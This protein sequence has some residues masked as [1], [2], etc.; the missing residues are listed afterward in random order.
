MD[1]TEGVPQ[2]SVLGGARSH[3]SACRVC[4]SYQYFSADISASSPPLRVCFE[5]PAPR[6]HSPPSAMNGFPTL[7]VPHPP[8]YWQAV[9][10][11]SQANRPGEQLC[12]AL[13]K[14]EERAEYVF[15]LWGQKPQYYVK[16]DRFLEGLRTALPEAC[17]QPGS[18]IGIRLLVPHPE[19][20]SEDHCVRED[21]LH[22]WLHRHP[23]LAVDRVRLEV[24][25]EL[26]KSEEATGLRSRK[27]ASNFSFLSI[28]RFHEALDAD[29]VFARDA[30]N[31]PDLE[32]ELT[33]T[34]EAVEAG[35]AAFGMRNLG[36][37]LGANWVT[38]RPSRQPFL[39]TAMA[40]F[41]RE[42]QDCQYLLDEVYLAER[43]PGSPD[44]VTFPGSSRITPCVS[45]FHDPQQPLKIMR[46]M[47]ALE[48][49]ALAVG[50]QSVPERLR[51][52]T[53]ST[54]SPPPSEMQMEVE[55]TV[56]T[57]SEPPPQ[58]FSFGMPHLSPSSAVT[59]CAQ[60]HS[61][62]LPPLTGRSR[63][64]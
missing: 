59:V 64:V 57:P 23:N 14:R 48:E 56:R 54:T 26:R 58:T 38:F 19:A 13:E 44:V 12:A 55:S 35:V 6:D 3:F 30:D 9:E 11:G 40:T 24:D 1:T 52:V 5:C 61:A 20:A 27:S 31:D 36:G 10:D 4:V 22:Y 16:L 41:L 60:P 32:Q 34:I 17:H 46:E 15:P 53:L 62:T 51:D 25:G 7:T 45:A 37:N 33:R 18:S 43:Y 2:V 28:L 8:F 39:S 29:V 50:G 21:V 42:H 49:K 47:S 63:R